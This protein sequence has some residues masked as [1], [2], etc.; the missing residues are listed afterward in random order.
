MVDCVAL[1]ELRN[2]EKRLLKGSGQ[3][4]DNNVL[5]FIVIVS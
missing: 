2:K 4:A 5:K 1:H 3:G